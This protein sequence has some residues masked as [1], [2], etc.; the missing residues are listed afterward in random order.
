MKALSII[1]SGAL[2]GCLVMAPPPGGTGTPSSPSEG[3]QTPTP[4]PVAAPSEPSPAAPVAP[5]GP[6]VVSVKLRNTCGKTVKMFFGQKPGFSSGR[7]DSMSSN[8]STNMQL[9]PGDMVWLTDDN[10]NGMASV[11]VGDTTSEIEVTC[12][13]IRAK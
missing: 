5:T 13:A 10:R 11:T 2:S 8:S 12:D 1:L 9:K 7:S 6:V 4:D 3:T